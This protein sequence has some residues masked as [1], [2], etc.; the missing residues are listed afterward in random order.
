MFEKFGSKVN[1]ALTLALIS[2]VSGLLLA[3]VNNVTEP[4]IESNNEQKV[5][6]LYTEM[7][8]EMD[9]TTELDHSSDV[10]SLVSIV[11]SDGTNIGTICG[12]SGTNAYGY[13]T[14]LVSF[15]SDKAVTGIEYPAFNQTPGFGDKVQKDEYKDQYNGQLP[16]GIVADAASGATYSS[17]L[18]LSLVNTC[19]V[20]I[21]DLP[22]TDAEAVDETT[23]ST[24][25]TE[26][27]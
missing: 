22:V 16:D 26:E 6:E 11:N 15:N 20:E 5:L 17:N 4:V 23:E 14:T 27:E 7:F 24:D 12:V 21:L 3:L 9:S 19:S 10:D 13:M 8:P 2:G 1:F 25:T 18:V